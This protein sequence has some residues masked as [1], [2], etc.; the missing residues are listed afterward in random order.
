MTSTSARCSG[1]E[2]GS[3][4]G[5]RA[6]GHRN[7]RRR[8]R[9]NMERKQQAGAAE[10]VAD[11]QRDGGTDG[12]REDRE[13]GRR[14]RPRKMRT[15]TR[16]QRWIRYLR[17]MERK[18][19]Q[20][21]RA[22]ETSKKTRQRKKGKETEEKSCLRQGACPK[23][24]PHRCSTSTVGLCNLHVHLHQTTVTDSQL[25]KIKAFRKLVARST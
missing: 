11:P 23:P 20:H 6:A 5:R 7:R 21:R 22:K 17:P 18:D 24:H 2:G 13:S 8:R 19:T 1:S 4:G 14:R 10:R 3:V 15:D 9:L 16:V 12:F 25:N